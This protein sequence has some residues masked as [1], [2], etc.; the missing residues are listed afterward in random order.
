[1]ILNA[2][3]LA[4]GQLGDPRFRRVLLLGVGLTIALLIASYAGVLWLVRW[5]VGEDASLP[6]I[7]PINWLND[8]NTAKAVIIIGLIWRWTGY[9]ALILLAAIAAGAWTF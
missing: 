9:N 6:F 4:L 3:F 1:M 5:L 7:G 2:F 8:P